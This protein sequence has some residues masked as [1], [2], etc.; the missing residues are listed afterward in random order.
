MA[1]LLFTFYF[2]L[3]RARQNFMS[4]QNLRLISP[5]E[6]LKAEFLA[7]AQEYLNHGDDY[8][9]YALE[10]FDSYLNNAR[11][12]ERGLNLPPHMVQESI[13]WLHGERRIF[14]R[15]GL[16]HRLTPALEQIGGHIGYDVRPSERRKGYGSL[17]LELTLEKA[18]N[19]GLR[20]VLIT[21]DTDN[22]GSAKI[23]EKNGGKLSAQEFL[24]TTGKMI[25][26]YWIEI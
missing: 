3:L 16:R 20:R 2:L 7:M 24:D 1:S 12:I 21:C 13:F 19:L 9:K 8:Y 10:N 11:R 25:S 14:G 4:L 17:I 6:E 5:N 22:I 18:K 26:R 15:S 23:I